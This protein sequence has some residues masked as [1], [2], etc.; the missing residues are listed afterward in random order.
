MV[1]NFH[2]ELGFH[3]EDQILREINYRNLVGSLLYISNRTRP[4][5][6]AAVAILATSVSKPTAFLMKSA[7][8]VLSYLRDTIDLHLTQTKSRS[9]RELTVEFHADSDFAGE[10]R[11][12]KSRTGWVATVNGNL[13]AWASRKQSCAAL[14]T[15]EAQYMALYEC[16]REAKRVRQLLTE[17]GFN[18]SSPTTIYCDNN[19]AID[20]ANSVK[21]LRNAKHMDILFHFVR[22]CVER[23][24]IQIARV[25]SKDNKADPFTKPL[26]N[27]L[28]V[29]H[30]ESIGL[31]PSMNTNALKPGGVSEPVFD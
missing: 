21:G 28:F 18:A 1:S 27:E 14:S 6:S 25:D 24:V 16:A 7:Y 9:F 19:A 31:L 4:D 12:R 23:R 11:D 29:K 17:L 22:E 3:K 10:K 26:S 15:A 20:W 30:R 5:I 13:F 8:R 2:N